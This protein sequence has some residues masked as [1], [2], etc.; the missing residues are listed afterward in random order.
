MLFMLFTF[1]KMYIHLFIFQSAGIV[2]AV[3][4]M[5]WNLLPLNSQ[6]CL[7]LIM[8]RANKPIELV[9]ASMVTMSLETLA[10]V[11]YKI[12]IKKEKHF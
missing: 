6:K 9:G 2:D 7:I 1:V 12:Y 10:K 4:Q 8:M 5:N 3:Y 11:R